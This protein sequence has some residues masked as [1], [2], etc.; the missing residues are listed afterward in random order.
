MLRHI[1]PTSFGKLEK[2]Q[3]DA[4]RI[5]T[6]LPIFT[7][8]INCTQKQDELLSLVEVILG[9]SSYFII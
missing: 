4:V 6:G 1:V 7:K 9:N 3:L 5:V 2:L 8:Q